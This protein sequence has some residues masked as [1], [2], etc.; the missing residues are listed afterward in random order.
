MKTCFVIQPFDHDVYDRRFDETFAPAIK[1]AGLI[2]D[3]VDRDP[4][5]SIPIQDIEQRIAGAAVCFADISEDNPNVWFELGFAIA[6]RKELCLVCS[7]KRIAYPF[8]VQHRNIIKYDTSNAGDFKK[9]GTDIQARLEALL[10]KEATVESFQ[11]NSP[12]AATEGL[13]P[14]EIALLALL[15][16]SPPGWDIR[17]Y[18]LWQN[19]DKAGFT[20][21]AAGVALRSLQNKGFLKCE[22]GED[23]EGGVITLVRILPAGESW[24]LENQ[25]KLTLRKLMRHSAASQP[26]ALLPPPREKPPF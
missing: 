10:M 20:A 8:D 14:H 11:D 17:P 7:T 3:R 1:A 22:D 18:Q 21:E 5:V 15:V 19:M 9:L 2:P 25:N 23:D 24:L 4:A 12:L 26:S 16:A 13:R 6:S